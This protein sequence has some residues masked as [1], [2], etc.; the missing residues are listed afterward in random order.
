MKAS[1]K[2]AVRALLLAGTAAILCACASTAKLGEGEYELKSNKV[3]IDRSEKS[4]LRAAE[5]TPYIR[6]QSATFTLGRRK[7]T[8][9]GVQSKPGG[10]FRG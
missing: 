2:N 6:Q 1:K 7:D 9:L 3:V 4:D 10:Q 8:T 5:I